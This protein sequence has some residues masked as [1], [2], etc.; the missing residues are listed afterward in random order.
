MEIMEHGSNS[1]GKTW[2]NLWK[3]MEDY[4]KIWGRK[5]GNPWQNGEFGGLASSQGLNLVY[6]RLFSAGDGRC[7]TVEA[8]G[9]C[10]EHL[11]VSINGGAPK[12][13]PLK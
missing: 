6:M 12:W 2:K 1:L 10:W 7:L 3:P 5:H 8:L 11:G 4:A 9:G 13:I